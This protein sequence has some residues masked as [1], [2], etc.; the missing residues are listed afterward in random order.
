MYRNTVLCEEEIDNFVLVVGGVLIDKVEDAL[1][2]LKKYLT[3]PSL[4]IKVRRRY[5][6][7]VLKVDV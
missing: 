7:K 5:S 6:S 2:C 1:L 3:R 4:Y